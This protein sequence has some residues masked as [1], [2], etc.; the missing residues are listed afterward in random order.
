M[1]FYCSCTL[2]AGKIRMIKSLK[3]YCMIWLLFLFIY[4][5]IFVTHII[6]QFTGAIYIYTLIIIFF[7]LSF[8]VDS[9]FDAETMPC[10]LKHK[11]IYFYLFYF[12]T[13]PFQSENPRQSQKPFPFFK[14]KSFSNSTEFPLYTVIFRKNK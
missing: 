11:F 6:V 3:N 5:I 1:I 12:L 10:K 9:N 4:Y 8:T 13:N 2:C 14:S 7:L